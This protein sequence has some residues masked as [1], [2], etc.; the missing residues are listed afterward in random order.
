M[1][2]KKAD[3]SAFSAIRYIH[4]LLKRPYDGN[5]FSNML[6]HPPQ[7]LHH[8][9][10]IRLLNHERRHKPDHLFPGAYKHQLLLQKSL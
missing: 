10:H 5:E 2:K 9:V 3:C 6:Q 1:E 8:L 4:M 7:P